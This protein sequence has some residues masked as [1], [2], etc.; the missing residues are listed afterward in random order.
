MTCAIYMHHVF[1]FRRKKKLRNN[2][3]HKSIQMKTFL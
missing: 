3:L 1:F 2:I